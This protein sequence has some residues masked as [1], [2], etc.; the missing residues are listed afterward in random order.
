MCLPE[1]RERGLPGGGG[2]LQ[3]VPVWDWVT[4]DLRKCAAGSWFDPAP[5]GTASSDGRFPSR[6]EGEDHSTAHCALLKAAM[7][8]E[9][10]FYQRAELGIRCGS[11]PPHWAYLRLIFDK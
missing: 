4:P 10:G 2:W 9:V 11:I 6:V 3:R 5:L 1:V 8:W 7:S